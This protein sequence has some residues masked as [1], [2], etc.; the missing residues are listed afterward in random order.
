MNL[1]QTVPAAR[2]RLALKQSKTNWNSFCSKV[3]K[4]P[5]EC[6]IL[7]YFK[8]EGIVTID[9]K[10]YFRRHLSPNVALK[11]LNKRKAPSTFLSSGVKSNNNS[12]SRSSL[13]NR[14]RLLKDTQE[15]INYGNSGSSRKLEEDE[16]E[17]IKVNN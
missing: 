16:E 12:S 7:N 17:D 2:M 9:L 4:D 14:R 10:S 6:R 3:E 13:W 1:D 15:K 11:A 5:K 8:D